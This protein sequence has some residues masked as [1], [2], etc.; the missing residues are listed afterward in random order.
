MWIGLVVG[1]GWR[2]AISVTELGHIK[3]VTRGIELFHMQIVPLCSLFLCVHCCVSFMTPRGLVP[4]FWVL[5]SICNPSLQ[6]S[7]AGFS[8]TFF[9]WPKLESVLHTD[10]P[11]IHCLLLPSLIY[12]FFV[13]FL[14]VHGRFILTPLL[15]WDFWE[16]TLRN[17]CSIIQMTLLS[18][19]L[20]AH[21]TYLCAKYIPTM[22]SCSV[23]NGTFPN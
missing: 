21:L 17:V 12:F 16:G 22:L 14:L 13:C 18:R 5:Q 8:Y 2:A 11:K 20:C 3:K 10:L 1:R 15:L 9:T 19:W 7:S 23:S 4:V 6:Y